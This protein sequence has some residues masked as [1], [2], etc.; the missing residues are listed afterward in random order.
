[1]VCG[2]GAGD[3]TF[4]LLRPEDAECWNGMSCP[5][6]A[7]RHDGNGNRI[8]N[9]TD[10]ALKQFTAHYKEATATG[11]AKASASKARKITKEAIF[12][13]CYAVLHD[14]VYREKYAQNLKREF[15]RIP[16]YG[17]VAGRLLAVGRLGRGL[18]G[19]AHRL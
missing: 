8:D 11:A 2:N 1:M 6:N 4:R 9:I 10:W 16:L 3:R 15:P 12:H 7:W 18:D 19:A 5:C 14:P 13:Y 17:S